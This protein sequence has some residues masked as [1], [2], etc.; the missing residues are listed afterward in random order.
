MADGVKSRRRDAWRWQAGVAPR[1][2]CPGLHDQSAGASQSPLVRPLQGFPGCL[3]GDEQD[4]PLASSLAST[5]PAQAA[6]H[7]QAV[8]DRCICTWGGPPGDTCTCAPSRHE[9]GWNGPG[10]GELC[11][12]A[13]LSPPQ[14]ASDRTVPAHRWHPTD[15]RGGV[16]GG[17]TPFASPADWHTAP[18][19][20]AVS[21]PNSRIGG[22]N[23]SLCVELRSFL[24][25]WR[26]ARSTGGWRAGVALTTPR[27]RRESTALPSFDGRFISKSPKNVLF[28]K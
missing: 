27:P 28:M 25:K 8:A 1:C 3:C 13:A 26:A 4:C 7:R 21:S 2:A 10:P 17:G 11:E 22:R 23:S 19:E 16:R 18:K 6:C 15:P 9:R 14:Y 12:L 20:G 24:S 5:M